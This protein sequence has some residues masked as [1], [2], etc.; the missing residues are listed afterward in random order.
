MSSIGGHASRGTNGHTDDEGVHY[1]CA[2]DPSGACTTYQFTDC[3]G[4]IGGLYHMSGNVAEWEDACDGTAANANC[5][6]RGGSFLAANDPT[7]L[8]C[9]G[10][11]MVQRVPPPPAQGE[12]DPLRDIGFRCCLY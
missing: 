8:S 2:T 1:S 5:R 7:T 10:M 6:V 3:N 4:G 9:G 12:M 11:R